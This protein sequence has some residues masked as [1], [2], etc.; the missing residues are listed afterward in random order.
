MSV[1]RATVLDRARTALGT[2]GGLVLTGH[3]GSGRSTLLASLA[4]RFTAGGHRVLRCRP[5]P[6]DQQLPYLGLID[7][8]AEVSDGE[9]DHL[10]D[11][12]REL[13]RSVLRRVTGTPAP[14]DGGR[15]LVLRMAL[16][17]ALARLTGEGPLLLVVD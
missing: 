16:L 10:P 1:D 4:D 2:G 11:D 9:L 15:L 6:A 13:L 5:A 7:L 12:E 17:R 14:L 8:L 3:P